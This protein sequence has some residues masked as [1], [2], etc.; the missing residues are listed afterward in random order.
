MIDY[1]LVDGIATIHF[2]DGKANVVSPAFS[3][4]LNE[5]LDRAEADKAGAVV[6]RGR[7]GMFSAGFDLGEFKKGVEAGMAM[8]IQGIRLAIRLYSFPLPV[9]AACT[10]HGIAMGAF[11]LLT[12]DNRIGV[13]GDYK[14]TLPE[15]AINMDI[16]RPLMAL[17]VDRL[18]PAY[19]TRAAVQAEVFT[20]DEAV[21]AGF[22]DEAVEAAELDAR[23]LALATALGALPAANY[24][25][26]K[27]DAREKTLAAMRAELEQAA[28][29]A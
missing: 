16:P 13:R 10:G 9:I 11:L 27:L 29:A 19:L 12:C 15:T 28:G 23:V 17:T 18:S 22:L 7:E 25:A 1:L 20:P 21:A 3:E 4:A 8:V 5:A 2:D 24:A 26:N 14:I 6:L